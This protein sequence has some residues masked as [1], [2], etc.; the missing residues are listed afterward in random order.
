[1][2]GR[3][4]MGLEIKK[5]SNGRVGCLVGRPPN[6]NHNNHTIHELK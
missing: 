5:T 4:Q 1:M 3:C 6:K 2:M